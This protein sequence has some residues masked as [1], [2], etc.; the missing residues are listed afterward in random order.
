MRPALLLVALF[1]ASS[2]ACGSDS[3]S[4]APSGPDPSTSGFNPPAAPEGYT[5]LTAK[6]IPAI[7]AGA[8]ITHCQYLMTPFDRDMDIVHVGGYQS[9][10]GHHAVA[11]SQPDDGSLELGGSIP[12]MGSEFNVETSPGGAG[13]RVTGGTYLGGVGGEGAEAQALPEGVAF[14]LKAGQ[15]I[16]L[17]LHYINTGDEPIDGNAV[18]DIKFVEADPNRNIAALFLNINGT[19]N[20]MPRTETQSKTEC[21]AKSEV[22]VLMMANHMHEY[23][24][25]ATTEVVRAGT[26]EVEVL[27][28]DPTWEYEMQFNPLY[29]TWPAENPFVLRVGDT[30]R[31]SCTWHNSTE[32]AIAFPREMCI[33]A[34]FA[35][36]NGDNP[37]APVCFQGNW[38]SGAGL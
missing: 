3:D 11:F 37:S 31:T 25:S 20:L 14:R 9:K 22:K 17:N 28:H 23:G 2:I 13:T 29:Q 16:L 34:G 18:V 7:E 21:V 36:A 6:T 38:F 33:A 1:S 32:Q 26:G 24:T 5:R 30:L 8:D 4:A 12:C 15:G 35:L 19:F 27:R 10:W